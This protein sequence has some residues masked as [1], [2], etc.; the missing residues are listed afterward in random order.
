M[1]ELQTT[2]VPVYFEQTDRFRTIEMRFVFM[3]DATEERLFLLELLT[4]YLVHTNQFYPAESDLVKR[5]MELFHTQFFVHLAGYGRK[6]CL[7]MELDLVDPSCL[8]ENYLEEAFQFFMQLSFSPRVIDD[9]FDDKVLLKIKEYIQTR[10]SDALTSISYYTKKK[11]NGLVAPNTFLDCYVQDHWEEI[12]QITGK[13]L[14]EFYQEMI[15]QVGARL[16]VMG[17][18][19]EEQL[20]SL[21]ER[22]TPKMPLQPIDREYT[23]W[24]PVDWGKVSH[25]YREVAPFHQSCLAVCFKVDQLV[26]DDQIV[27]HCLTQLL[28]SS[29]SDLF[30]KELRGKR[31]LVYYTEVAYKSKYGLL[32]LMAFLKR[33]NQTQAMEGIYRVL[34]Q[35]RDR[36]LVSSLL[37]KLVLLKEDSLKRIKDRSFYLFDEM[38][39]EVYGY[40]YTKLQYLDGMR[41]VTAED[42]AS[43]VDRLVFDTVYFVEGD[44]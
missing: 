33:G 44:R 23:C 10:A 9:H 17:N 4:Q 24:L 14:Y 28:S 31:N 40:G 19:E 11:I 42:I 18:L 26:E 29:V 27:L 6:A 35:L 3:M 43:L 1:K 5:S 37:E 41:T 34:Q 2:K 16:F 38:V 25:F 13:Q 21:V 15:H 22:Y 7:E 32:S 8:G 30:E 36:E 12:D 20:I 39:V